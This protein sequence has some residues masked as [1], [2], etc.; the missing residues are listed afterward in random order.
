MG[1]GL[2]E[3]AKMFHF[4]SN[5]HVLLSVPPKSNPAPLLHSQTPHRGNTLNIKYNCT[6]SIYAHSRPTYY[7][8]HTVQKQVD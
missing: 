4:P 7:N 5:I 6:V 2:Q 1:G 8:T 3:E